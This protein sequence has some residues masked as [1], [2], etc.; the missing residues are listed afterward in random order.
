MCSALWDVLVEVEGGVGWRYCCM[1]SG[2]KLPE[3]LSDSCSSH[4]Y[5]T[6]QESK[7][8]ADTSLR[9]AGWSQQFHLWVN[10]WKSWVCVILMAECAYASRPQ[11]SSS[12]LVLSPLFFPPCNLSCSLRKYLHVISGFKKNKEKK[13][14]SH[15]TVCVFPAV[16]VHPAHTFPFCPFCQNSHF[17]RYFG[18][19]S[20]IP[21]AHQRV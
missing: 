16:K 19:K 9:G 14:E 3:A 5:S 7:V 20:K 15:F 17:F 8:N 21:S 6:E 1:S 4:P 12:V 18:D 13:V 2:W 11:I 10:I